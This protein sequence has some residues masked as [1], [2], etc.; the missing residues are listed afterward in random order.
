MLRRFAYK[1]MYSLYTDVYKKV[2][3]TLSR[4]YFFY[5]NIIEPK[6]FPYYT[7]VV[8]SYEELVFKYNK[9]LVITIC[10]IL[11]KINEIYKNRS[12]FLK[13]KVIFSFS[14]LKEIFNY[15]TYLLN[16]MYI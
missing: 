6:M 3:E 7:K 13:K 1:Y 14:K 11:L 10:L 15:K 12:K 16:N 8:K 5:I 4:P 2:N 9:G